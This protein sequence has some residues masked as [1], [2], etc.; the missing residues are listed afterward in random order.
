MTGQPFPPSPPPPPAGWRPPPLRA[1]LR[2]HPGPA[3]A[4]GSPTWTLWDPVNNRFFR[5]GWL[6]YLLLNHWHAPSVPSLIESVHRRAGLTVTPERIREM[7]HFLSVNQLV[8]IVDGP[9]IHGLASREM[10][11]KQRLWHW[12]LHHYLFF[13][14]PLVRPDRFLTALLPVVRVAG[15]RW[16]RWLLVFITLL[17]LYLTV[18]QWESF[19]NGF[20]YFFTLEGLL[21]YGGAIL[22]AK[23]VHELGHAFTARH[24][25]CRVP[26]MGVAFMVLWPV[27]YTDT[28]AAWKLTDRRARL[29]IDAAGILAELGLA[30]LATL[31]WHF[32]PDGPLRSAMVLLATVTWVST[33]MVNLNPFMRFDGYYL[34]S[35]L[36]DMANL[37]QRSFALA[38][39]HLRETLFRFGEA[40]P[41]RFSD[42]RRRT[43]LLF[44]YGAWLYRL[45][46][47]IGIALLVYHLVFKLA[48]IFLM[49]VE[50][51]WFVARPLWRE[52][53]AWWQ[54][55]S[56]WRWNRHTLG[57]LMAAGLVIAL[58]IIPWQSHIIAPAL[59]EATPHR[60][61]YPPTAARIDR[62]WVKRGQRVEKGATLITL[63][64]PDLD[65]ELQ[66]IT[67]RLR[68]LR[69]EI[70]RETA[71]R[72]GPSRH[73]VL[74]ETLLALE[75][76]KR[77]YLEQRAQLT[78]TAPF[79]G[80]V[81][82]VREGLRPGSWVAV[83][84][85]LAALAN[86]AGATVE[87]WVTE[88]DIARIEANP[89]AGFHPDHGPATAVPLR[90]IHLD[91][92]AATT[93]KKP[94]FSSSHGG[95]IATRFN[96]R[97][98]MIPNEAVYR[99]RFR[100]IST[101]DPVRQTVRGR[102]R[103]AVERHSLI[104]RAITL[105][106]A[107]WIRESGF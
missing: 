76:E 66:R 9:G 51:G 74:R 89:R 57:T 70:G 84:T 93:L 11:Q 71:R 100:P 41:E 103:I 18:R 88:D 2:L 99:L 25:G 97:Q 80:S 107:V 82:M 52:M 1:D 40:P 94:H 78:L 64:S 59:L 17:G 90:L 45:V 68:T 21:W 63:E 15:S 61:L 32:L 69:W 47:F 27:L 33:L 10:A 6:E 49:A 7:A 19:Q 104:K 42:R 58:L 62:V 106:A 13:R 46:L 87:A 3:R 12:L 48:G 77:G 98:E 35:D 39:W 60:R 72:S 67:T 96:H 31:L 85:P 56:R 8:R 34:L 105:V 54:R 30:A 50:L 75:T 5:L 23:V 14:I 22:L 81:V 37:Q 53:G 83:T 16:F 4:D 91:P 79:A 36:L 26:S 95:E 86:T 44:A 24:H 28:S 102:V 55:R 65:H 73:L 29:A 101:I 38:R 20:L 92:T 43:L